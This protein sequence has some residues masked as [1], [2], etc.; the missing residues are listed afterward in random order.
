MQAWQL[1]D[2]KLPNQ[3]QHNHCRMQQPFE[4]RHFHQDVGSW[5]KAEEDKD[6]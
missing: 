2:I 5:Y 4:D 3:H 1:L 6:I